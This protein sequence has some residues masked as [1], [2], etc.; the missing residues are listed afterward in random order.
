[1]ASLESRT[2]CSRLRYGRYSIG[3]G[4]FTIDLS[5]TCLLHELMET[6]TGTA[7]AASTQAQVG[8]SIAGQVAPNGIPVSDARDWSMGSRIFSNLVPGPVTQ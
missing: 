5:L 7:L 1:M 2:S 3:K 8:H 4:G 6:K